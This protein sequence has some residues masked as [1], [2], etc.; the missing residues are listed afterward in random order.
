MKLLGKVALITGASR[1]I[2]RE[3]ALQLAQEGADIVIAARTA[4][5]GES[6]Y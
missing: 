1:G 5:A 2:G 3:L 6:P 4:Q